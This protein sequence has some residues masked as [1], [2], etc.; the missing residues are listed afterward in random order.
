MGSGGVSIAAKAKIITTTYFLRSFKNFEL[1]LFINVWFA[2][3][4]LRM[5]LFIRPFLFWFIRYFIQGGFLEGRNGF[6]WNFLQCLWYR[7]LVDVKIFE[8]YRSAGRDRSKLIEYFAKNYNLD[9]TLG[10]S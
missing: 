3:V 1:P 7:F 2:Q 6:I 8:A 10:G 9:V 4:D 5:P